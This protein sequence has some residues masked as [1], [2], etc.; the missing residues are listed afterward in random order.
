MKWIKYLAV[1]SFPIL[2]YI[3]FTQRGVLTFL[4]IIEAFVLL[5]FLEVIISPD[6]SN[7]KEA[8]KE[9]AKRDKIYDLLLYLV[10]IMLYGFLIFYVF[11]IQEAGLGLIDKIGRTLSMGLLAGAMGINVAH[12]LGHRRTKF[13]QFLAKALLLPS[14]YTH[15]YIEHNKGHHKNVATKADPATARLNESVYAFW[16]RVIPKSWLSAWEISKNEL[17]RKKKSFWSADNEMLMLQLSQLVYL[18]FVYILFG[19]Q[20]LLFF[21]AVAAI[22]IILLESIE[23]IEHYGLTRNKVNERRYENV[24]PKHS[25]NSNHVLG[26]IFLFELTRHSDHH[27]DPHKKYQLLD[28]WE[29]APQLPTGYPGSILLSLIPPLWYKIMNPKVKAALKKD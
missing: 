10:P 12:E 20:I 11:S 25:W 14:L 18:A 23:Y 16:L 19:A 27:F 21:L 6:S 3:S 17:K 5:P 24:R 2:T 26:R 7:L 13:E 9:V 1:F 15:F 22:G 28:N 8:E 29:E 4:P